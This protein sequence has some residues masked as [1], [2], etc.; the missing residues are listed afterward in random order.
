MNAKF[1]A[2]VLLFA[3]IATVGATEE[4]KEIEQSD[5][6]HVTEHVYFNVT[7][8]G[9]QIGRIVI[10][11]FGH[12]TPLTA[13]NFATICRAGIRGMSYNGTRFHRVIR[14]FMIQ[15]GDIVNGNG[16]GGI[17]IYGPRFN[18]ENFMV[19]HSGPGYVS[20]ANAGPNTNGCQ[21]FITT[22]PTPHLNGAHVVFGKVVEGMEFVTA[23]ELN[24]TDAQDRPILEAV[25]SE[26]GSLPM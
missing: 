25:I 7:I 11:L 16:S 2:T 13:A 5:P 23:I 24:P 10:G 20:M 19:A 18:D 17:S 12:T 21:F 14:S 3:I 1:F 4:V 22:I 6:E 15:G 9:Q 26:C 8:D